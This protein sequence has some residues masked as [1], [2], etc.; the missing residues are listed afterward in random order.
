M[1]EAADDPSGH[2]P[3]VEPVTVSDWPTGRVV[4]RAALT[5]SVGLLLTHLPRARSGDPEGVHQ[6]RVASRR[7]RS[8]L[9]TFRA[10][11]D[12]AWAQSLRERLGAFTR[13]FGAVR[14][15]DVMV[16]ALREVDADPLLIVAVEAQRATHRKALLAVLDEPETAELLEALVD[17]ARYPRTE[18]AADEPADD[19]LPP[20]VRKRWNKLVR[21]IDALG[22]HPADDDLHHARI[23]TKQ[24]RYAAMAVSPVFGKPALAFA[25]TLGALQEDLGAH[26]DMRV[27]GERLRELATA[28]GQD[29][30][31]AF[32]AGEAVGRLQ[33]RAD[34][35]RDDW[36]R[37]WKRASAKKR[38]RWL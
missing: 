9:R 13:A 28:N 34:D 15:D 17:A 33:A 8:D 6:C 24:C 35:H 5:D 30:A 10:F 14:D 21:T 38:R 32:A 3:A 18:P 20:L 12:R 23:V 36:R 29:A 4:V 26:N 1:D 16:E 7:L 25:K 22:K 31:L 11:L 37:A 27:M 2:G 19:V